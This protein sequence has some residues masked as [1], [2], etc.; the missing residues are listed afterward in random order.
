MFVLKKHGG[1]A[2]RLLGVAAL[3]LTYGCGDFDL[4]GG[5]PRSTLSSA[6]Y[7]AGAESPY[8]ETNP[9]N[10]LQS[11]ELV[12]INEESRLIH[13]TISG[14]SDVDVY[15]L[16]PVEPG[17]RII[18]EMTP[19]GSLDGAVALFDESGAALL[20]NDHRNIYLGRSQ[21]YVDVVIRKPGDACYV[22]ASATPGY[23][24]SGDYTLLAHKAFADLPAPKSDRVLLVFT[25]GSGVVIGSRS[26]I[27]VPPF[28]ATDIDA[29]FAGQTESMV[30]Q[31]VTE[32]RKDY[33]GL[34]IEILSTSEGARYEGDMSRLFFGEFDAALLGVAEGVDEFNATRSQEAIVFTD[35]FEVFL[36]IQ[37]TTTEMGQAIANVAS[38]EIGH[39]MGLV[40]TADPAG[41]MDVTASLNKLLLDQDFRRSPLYSEVFPIGAQDAVELLLASLGGDPVLTLTK[42][43]NGSTD[44][45]VFVEPDGPPARSEFYLSSC[46]LEDH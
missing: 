14:A 27:N 6:I 17:D 10:F 12:D 40:H 42:Y 45:R 30:R 2:A 43:V 39:L 46:G 36:R 5:Q 44:K 28:D 38:H 41:I 1:G 37:P 22:A 35:T 21:P 11:A 8:F 23:R 9:N 3:C 32:V 20:V 7:A 18:V 26:A 33:A 29:R 24:A 34:D 13:G 16:G 19:S 25:G 31:I 15:D 4:F